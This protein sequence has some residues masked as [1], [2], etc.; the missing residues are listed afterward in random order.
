MYSEVGFKRVRLVGLSTLGFLC[1]PLGSTA[2]W[3]TDNSASALASFHDDVTLAL[4]LLVALGGVLTL[5]G[6]LRN[7]NLLALKLNE[8]GRALGISR[9]R[10]AS[11]GGIGPLAMASQMPGM[12]HSSSTKTPGSRSLTNYGAPQHLL[13]LEMKERKRV[14]AALVRKTSL[15]ELLQKVASA[16][17]AATNSAELSRFCVESVCEFAGWSVGQAFTPVPSGDGHF[18]LSGLCYVQRK[19]GQTIAKSSR[20]LEGLSGVEDIVSE[21]VHA[22]RPIWA[23]EPEMM[24]SRDRA[25]VIFSAGL[26][27]GIWVPIS[28]KSEVVCLFE[29]LADE[30]VPP[31]EG[32]AETLMHIAGH[33]GR[34]IE[35]ERSATALKDSEDRFRRFSDLASEGI[36][37]H[38]DGKVVEANAA[39]EEITGYRPDDVIGAEITAYL[40]TPYREVINSKLND[41]DDTR[42]EVVL[43]RKDGREVVIDVQGKNICYE[44]RTAR[45]ALIRDV[46]A[47]KTSQKL[48][49][50]SEERFRRLSEAAFEAVVVHQDGN[51]VEVN[52]AFL[53]MFRYE[54]AEEVIGQPAL[55]LVSPEFRDMSAEKIRKQDPAHYEMEMLRKDGATI[56]VEVRARAIPYLGALAR[57]ATLN[58]ITERKRTEEMLREREARLTLLVEQMPAVLWSV[59]TQLNLIST[60]GAGLR[61]LN[62]AGR[63]PTAI[64]L[65]EFFNTCDPN[66]PALEVHRRA[67][68]GEPQS[69]EMD[70]FGLTFEAH[71]E[72]MRNEAGAIT[73]VIGVALDITE[74]KQSEE[75]LKVAAAELIRSN[76]ELEQFAY[77]ASHDLQEPLRMISSYIDLLAR[78]YRGSLGNE[79]DEFIGFAVDGAKRMKQQIDDLLEYSRV[80]RKGNQFCPVNCATVFDMVLANLKL[81]TQESGA[82]IKV[83]ELPVVL[84]DPVQLGQLF[85]NLVSNALKFRSAHPPRIAISA[86]KDGSDWRFIIEDNGIGLEMEYAER[87]FLIFQRLHTVSE[88]PGT[89][90]GLALCKKIVERHGGRI[91]VQSAKGEGSR[92]QFTLPMP[93]TEKNKKSGGLRPGG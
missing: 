88:Y 30:R 82:E 4:P 93:P 51:I 36:I 78:R 27:T 21:A 58:D 69:F 68:L 18:V 41:G 6:L 72:P 34:V 13:R 46:T 32:L 57:V 67:L 60:V 15:L 43:R 90:I 64:G 89:G 77:V 65:A 33:V 14:E 26:R 5:W 59:D 75:K 71:I 40:L 45:V 70:W 22:G 31:D 16:A 63:D 9:I 11:P 87:I 48:L 66:F 44:G 38:R 50:E 92:F 2:L 86:Q 12:S 23:T 76:R 24:I 7:F 56:Y 20:L 61:L 1:L 91:W 53:K 3:A 28:L 55:D 39:I 47:Q 35:R 62:L 29:F 37:I 52:N 49:V 74:R 73:G 10:L 81:A 83:G 8:V 80:N 17:N 54:R 42:S 84:G 25:E 19:P 85:Q 79:A